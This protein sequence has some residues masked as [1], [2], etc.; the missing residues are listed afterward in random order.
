MNKEYI[1]DINVTNKSIEVITY[2]DCNDRLIDRTEFEEWCDDQ[3]ITGIKDTESFNS[4]SGH[5]TGTYEFTFDHLLED[6]IELNA[7]VC[8]YI[9]S[10][11]SIAA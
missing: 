5:S 9:N 10:Q 4:F 7:A 1:V 3:G 2:D 6:H 8:R 11:V